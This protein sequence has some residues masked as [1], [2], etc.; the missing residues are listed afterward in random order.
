MYLWNW[1]TGPSLISTLSEGP[2]EKFL[3]FHELFQFRQDFY[4][5]VVNG[6]LWNASFSGYLMLAF[7]IKKQSGNQLL[8]FRAETLEAG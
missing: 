1:G 7:I 6:P 8:F 5:S 4:L 2:A 3:I